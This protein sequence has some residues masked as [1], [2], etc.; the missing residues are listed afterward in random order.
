MTCHRVGDAFSG[1]RGLKISIRLEV[2]GDLGGGGVLAPRAIRSAGWRRAA[3]PFGVGRRPSRESVAEESWR[4]SIQFLA[5]SP[6][7]STLQLKRKVRASSQALRDGPYRPRMATGP[8]P[9]A[10][11][12]RSARDKDGGARRCSRQI[13]RPLAIIALRRRPLQGRSGG[14]GKRERNADR[15]NGRGPSVG[16]KNLSK[17]RRA[18]KA[19]KI[20]G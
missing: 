1:D 18:D 8:R 7:L 12:A 16:V 11:D 2:T 14:A 3:E 9:P 4:P 19:A 15:D 6:P 17:H 20:V 13:V 10:H 5:T